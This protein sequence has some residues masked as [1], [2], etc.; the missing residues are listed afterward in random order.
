VVDEW[1]RKHTPAPALSETAAGPTVADVVSEFL[2]HYAEAERKRPEQARYLLQKNVIPIIG[3]VPVA[4]LRK[5][6][7]VRCF[8]RMKTRGSPVL[9][10]RVCAILKQAFAVSADRDLIESVPVFPRDPPGG[11]EAPRERV[12]DDDEIK[13][14]WHGLDT[15]SPTDKRP[16]IS[17]PLV[18]ALKLALVTA[19]RR[20][21]IAVARWSDVVK[22]TPEPAIDNNPA[23]VSET[24]MW[25]IADTKTGRPHN[26]PLS[27]LASRLLDELRTFAGDSDFWL[28]SQRTGLAN[29]ERDRSI[30]AAARDARIALNMQEWTPHDLRRTART[31]MARLGVREEVAERVLNHVQGNRMI[32]V[33]N[34][35]NYQNEMRDALEKWAS[36]LEDLVRAPPIAQCALA[37]PGRR[38]VAKKHKPR[39]NSASQWASP[40]A[41]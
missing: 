41:R 28:P 23:S 1:H 19:Q 36:H 13:A 32:A 29:K 18:L 20:G 21:E 24:L 26:V 4:L 17:R 31:G 5:R 8:D 27:P 38:R 40:R 34:Q 7:L 6:E 11:R 16:K 12:L 37:A 10:N 3:S 30:T 33:Y 35:H 25:K 9:A 22:K 2:T 14:L 15:L 39:S